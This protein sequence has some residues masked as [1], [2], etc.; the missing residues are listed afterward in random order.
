LQNRSTLLSYFQIINKI[1]KNRNTQIAFISIIFSIIFYELFIVLN[2]GKTD[3]IGYPSFNNHNPI[4]VM[5]KYL[6][7][8]I[9]L[10]VV[11]FLLYTLIN[12]KKVFIVNQKIEIS[13]KQITSKSFQ[14]ASIMICLLPSIY[15]LGLTI[16]LKVL[17]LVISIIVTI[18]I[19]KIKKNTAKFVALLC[20]LALNIYLTLL[21]LWVINFW[22][23]TDLSKFKFIVI[24]V[25]GLSII[26]LIIIYQFKKYISSYE[27]L[28]KHLLVFNVLIYIFNLCYNA[29]GP[30]GEIDVFHEGEWLAPAYFLAN[31]LIPYVDFQP[32]HGLLKDG[33]EQFIGFKL[34]GTTIYSARLIDGM[35]AKPLM[36]IGF[37]ILGLNIFKKNAVNFTLFFILIINLDI[38]NR[39]F[40]ADFR[41]API[42]FFVAYL[43]FINNNILNKK[44]TAFFP[45]FSVL[46]MILSPELFFLVTLSNVYIIVKIIIYSKFNRKSL[47][48][49]LLLTYLISGLFLFAF[50][51]G[52]AM[53]RMIKEFSRNL[54]HV[55]YLPVDLSRID[56]KAT[57]IL[58]LALVL[59]FLN[60]IRITIRLKNETFFEENLGIILI[61]SLATSVGLSKYFTRADTH[62]YE[63]EPI[64]LALILVS[65]SKFDDIKIKRQINFV[66]KSNLLILS[67][68]FIFISFLSLNI[69]HFRNPFLNSPFKVLDKIG[70]VIP[71]F[72]MDKSYLDLVNLKK[73]L[74]Q[75]DSSMRIL[76]FSNAPLATFFYAER[77]PV[78]RFFTMGSAA[79]P[80]TQRTIINDLIRDPSIVIWDGP[81]F[82]DW[83]S[84]T[85][86]IRNYEVSDYLINNYSPIDSNRY[87][88]TLWQPNEFDFIRKDAGEQVSEFEC[89]FYLSGNNFE[90]NFEKD[91][92]QL[93][94]EILNEALIIKFNVKENS[95]LTN[96]LIKITSN[97]KILAVSKI[98]KSE[99]ELRIPFAN[100]M[101]ISKLNI[102]FIDFEQ[103]VK[104]FEVNIDPANL[105][106][107]VVEL[108]NGLSLEYNFTQIKSI[109]RISDFSNIQNI[110]IQPIGEIK[111]E[112][113][114]LKI[115]GW[116]IDAKGEPFEKIYVI[117]DVGQIISEYTPDINRPDL[118]SINPSTN[119]NY[120]FNIKFY[121]NKLDNEKEI[122]IVD[123]DFKSI[124]MPLNY[125]KKLKDYGYI[126][127]SKPQSSFGWLEDVT[128]TDQN[129]YLNLDR[130]NT[131]EKISFAILANA[132]K[133]EIPIN[134]CEQNFKGE[135][136]YGYISTPQEENEL[137]LKNLKVFGG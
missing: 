14:F 72:E 73:S 57:A 61:L 39:M 88:Y 16:Y 98:G 116:A 36:V 29:P 43:I 51:M 102:A 11:F 122:F 74:D 44:L 83:D 137:E 46:I 85:N 97:G 22:N 18:V 24:S 132:T 23:F 76:D 9:F 77:L 19:L 37:Y 17:L 96:N 110:Q 86:N 123:G 55:S 114:I 129:D 118:S 106:S 117:D 108:T 104:S 32:I 34:F 20:I 59:P 79:R 49:E 125:K 15:L 48:K 27:I 33:I 8:T 112:T 80:S 130:G 4:P 31:G 94:S 41:Y 134:A 13:S 78:S 100:Y 128:A 64:L 10:P 35:I 56:T 111:S 124:P 133:I 2:S 126:I 113:K 82:R 38:F 53:L 120:G 107:N 69:N 84:I 28:L 81:G 89:E 47:P 66:K 58:V 121:D 7:I 3:I 90:S 93:N 26:V 105:D 131:N 87:S 70:P 101:E 109:L 65:I 127:G 25:L 99:I 103:K 52:I 50:P 92:V 71:E 135:S 91:R 67:T 119:D 75:F 42:P 63:V 30:I 136:Y 45:I 115:S 62:I 21:H 60:Y 95:Q 68:I 54:W 12:Y 6:S 1:I 5:A 40:Y